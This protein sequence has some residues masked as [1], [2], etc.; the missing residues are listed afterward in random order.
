[1]SDCKTCVQYDTMGSVC[2]RCVSLDKYEPNYETSLRIENETQAAEIAEL[3]AELKKLKT[4][5]AYNK[6]P[7][8][9]EVSHGA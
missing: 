6:L 5:M 4:Q 2:K 8:H 9:A 7:G 1:M 3:K